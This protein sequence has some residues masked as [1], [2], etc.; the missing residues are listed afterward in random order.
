MPRPI[1]VDGLRLSRS[2]TEPSRGAVCRL[3]IC[4]GGCCGGGIWL[5]VLHVQRILAHTD[6]I[7]ALLAP[8]RRD[9][10]GWFSDEVMDHADF[11]SGVGTATAIGPRPDGSGRDGCVFLVADNCCA[12]QRVSE[13]EGLGWPGLKPFDCATF[14]ILRSEGAVLWDH[15]TAEAI[16]GEA[17]CKRPAAG[18]GPS[19]ASV[20][21]AEAQLALGGR[22]VERMAQLERRRAARRGERSGGDGGGEGDG[23]G[24][25]A[26]Q[27]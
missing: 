5:D 4:G 3:E 20:F 25:G 16:P 14:P 10:D 15:R 27:A 11:P 7:A 8:A 26:G 17:D 12:L 22:G 24:D 23:G 1:V 13:A 21:V 2:L 19:L 9:P 6:A 18:R